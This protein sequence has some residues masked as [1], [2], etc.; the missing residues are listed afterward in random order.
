M[1]TLYEFLLYSSKFPLIFDVLYHNGIYNYLGLMFVLIPFFFM[2]LFYYLL[3]YPYLK[4]WHWLV[5]LLLIGLVTGVV[6]GVFVS[7]AILSSGNQL[8]NEA[9][10]DS[11]SGYQQYANGLPFKYAF[12]NI[13]LGL[14]FGFIGSLIIRPWSKIQIHLPF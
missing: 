2:F 11:S 10:A 1:A 9:L 4:F 5:Y 8:L 13:L 6:S 12:Y 14:L 3:K 7:N